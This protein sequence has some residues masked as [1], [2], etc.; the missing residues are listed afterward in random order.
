MARL[1]DTTVVRHP[2][3]G[4][5]VLLAAGGPLPDWA[6]ALVGDHLLSEPR[7]KAAAQKPAAAP[8]LTP[9]ESPEQERARLLARLA[10]LG[11]PVDTGD[12]SA[13]TDDTKPDADPGPPPKG[14]VGSDAEAWRAYAASRGVEV[15]A[16]AKRPAIVAALEAA[17]VPT[18]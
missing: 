17:G 2:E 1:T 12:T 7:P 8:A 3:T 15:P 16:D 4:E 13:D 6:T 5:A 11:G 10:E 9:V 14:R 18:E